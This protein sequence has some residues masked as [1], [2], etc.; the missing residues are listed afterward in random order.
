MSINTG[1]SPHSQAEAA[2]GRTKV[3][4]HEVY[5]VI[6]RKILE[7]E[8]PPATKI[9]I[10]QISD[11]LG[12][13]QTPVRE[14]LRL[15]Q[16]ETLLVATSNKGYATTDLLDRDQMRALYEFRLLIEPWAA[17]MATVNS[18]RNPSSILGAELRRFEV[19]PESARHLN[20]AHDDRFHRAIVQATGNPNV[21]EAYEQSHCHLHLFRLYHR[22]ADWEP[23]IAE[24]RNIF[25]AIAAK[26]SDLAEKTTRTHLHNSYKRFVTGLIDHRENFGTLA[27]IPL[28]AI[29]P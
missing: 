7:H 20:F 10:H 13:S 23:A 16:G 2:N 21:V 6:R 22:D 27:D 29:A 28:G 12:V 5:T 15:L 24:H 18:L 8:I 26:D 1:K 11:E 19:S 4:T 14:A 9:S 25:Q 3:S 17:R